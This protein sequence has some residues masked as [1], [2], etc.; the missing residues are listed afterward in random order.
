MSIVSRKKGKGKGYGFVYGY[1]YGWAVSDELNAAFAA[2]FIT[3]HV[4]VSFHF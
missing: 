4:F 2:K 1:G 3:P